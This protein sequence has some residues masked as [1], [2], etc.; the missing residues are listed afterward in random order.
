MML[1]EWAL[2]PHADPWAVSQHQP[3]PATSKGRTALTAPAT[4]PC[5]GTAQCHSS[6]PST[7]L[8]CFLIR[9]FQ[10]FITA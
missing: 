5:T 3:S 6:T 2:L 8:G 10:I 9:H 1:W 7:W 4:H